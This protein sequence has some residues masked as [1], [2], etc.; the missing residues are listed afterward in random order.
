MTS[1]AQEL[2]RCQVVLQLRAVIEAG[3]NMSAAAVATGLHRN[4]IRRTL[5]AA[6]YTSRSL[7][8]LARQRGVLR[9]RKPVAAVDASGADRRAA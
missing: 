9:S 6:G 4:T 2:R 3:G 8:A 5:Y 1:Y 7:M